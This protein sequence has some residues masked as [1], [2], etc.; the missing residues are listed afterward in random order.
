MISLTFHHHLGEIGRVRSLWFDQTNTIHGMVWVL[1]YLEFHGSWQSFCSIRD[2]RQFIKIKPII[3]QMLYVWMIF[4]YI[5]WKNGHIQGRNVGKY[6]LHGAT[7][8]VFFFSGTW[9]RHKTTSSFAK[10]QLHFSRAVVMEPPWLRICGTN[11]TIWIYK[12]GP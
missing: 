9:N 12:V 4:T 1:T 11:F 5:R 8:Y 6:S 3:S 10:I 2:A 7:G